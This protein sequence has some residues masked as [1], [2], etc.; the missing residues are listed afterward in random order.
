M[1]QRRNR[2]PR[3][4]RA[5]RR[6]NLDRVWQVHHER[7]EPDSLARSRSWPQEQVI[8]TNPL[9]RRLRRLR[10]FF[11]SSSLRG[12]AFSTDRGGTACNGWREVL[13]LTIH[14]ASPCPDSYSPALLD[15]TRL[16]RR[17]CIFADLVRL[18]R[19]FY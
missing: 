1:V 2:P 18:G 8:A 13:K 7:R 5:G 3:L 11:T 4:H 16:A 14:V 15:A 9:S 12:T 6:L 10:R 17:P 19:G